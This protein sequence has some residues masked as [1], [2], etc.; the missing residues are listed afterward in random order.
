MPE[1]CARQSDPRLEQEGF[2]TLA[3]VWLTITSLIDCM[4]VS[5]HIYIRRHTCTQNTH[6]DR[7]TY[8][9]HPNNAQK[10]DV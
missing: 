2:A 10:A 4:H 9:E 3:A 5:V 8:L 1:R 7:F 6:T